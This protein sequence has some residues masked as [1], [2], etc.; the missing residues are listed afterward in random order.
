MARIRQLPGFSNQILR[1]LAPRQRPQLGNDA[2]GAMSIAPVLNLEKGPLIMV[3]AAVEQR[4]GTSSHIFPP[5]FVFRGRAG[6]GVSPRRCERI[7]KSP[8]TLPDIVM[9][10]HDKINPRNLAGSLLI[11]GSPTP[12]DNHL[13]LTISAILPENRKPNGPPNRLAA[14]AGRIH[15]HTA[16]VDDPQLGGIGIRLNPPMGPQQRGHLLAFVLVDLATQCLDGK[17]PHGVE[18]S[19]AKQNKVAKYASGQPTLRKTG[20]YLEIWGNF[21]SYLNV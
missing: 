15:R 19:I 10:S 4:Q 12:R 8:K 16:C 5:P 1:R 6:V 9:V 2:I 3:L 17:R 18:G 14:L 20:D 11:A 7:E 21:S 13:G